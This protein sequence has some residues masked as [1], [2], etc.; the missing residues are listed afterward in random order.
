MSR[1]DQVAQEWDKGD[2]RQEI[3][4][5]TAET[6][7]ANVAL[8]DR[9]DLLDFGAGTGL[10]TYRIAPQVR[11]VTAVDL[12]PRMLEVL[13]E[14]LTDDVDICTVCADILQSP[15]ET[16]FDGIISSMAMHH[17]EDTAHFMQ[18]L[19]AHLRPGGFVAIADLD[20][21]D[22]SFHAHGNDGVY[23]FGFNK[24]RLAAVMQDAGFEAVTFHD[25]LTVQKP[26]RNYP[27]F[28]AVAHR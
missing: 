2:I 23:H 24:E 26:N 19:H 25:A 11:S 6:I 4:A 22:G 14:K 7:R 15:L 3:A 18:S 1:F 10:L 9:M 16:T 27:I 8:N 28:L 21:E 20:E 12:S 5:R 17:V 13:Q